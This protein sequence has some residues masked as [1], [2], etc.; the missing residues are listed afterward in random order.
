[1]GSLGVSTML[2]LSVIVIVVI[3]AYIIAIKKIITSKLSLN[4]KILWI[5]VILVFNF[6]GL[7]AFLVF[8]EIILPPGLRGELRW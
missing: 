7:V 3:G 5:L 4:Q 1:M 2:F 6:L 8:H